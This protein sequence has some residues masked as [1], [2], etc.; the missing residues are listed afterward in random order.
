MK[1]TTEPLE[2]WLKPDKSWNKSDI[3]LW[4]RAKKDGRITE[5]A[6]DRLCLRYASMQLE[7]I[8]PDLP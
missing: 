8:H 4:H 6:A 5:E 7:L 3:R 1:I 2:L